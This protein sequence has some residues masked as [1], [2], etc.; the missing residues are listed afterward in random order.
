MQLP[1]RYKQLNTI[2]V[3]LLFLMQ[4]MQMGEVQYSD[5]H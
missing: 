5:V 4:K 3:L 1:V 2:F